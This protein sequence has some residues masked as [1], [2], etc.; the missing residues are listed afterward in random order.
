[1][2]RK[3]HDVARQ[4]NGRE[5]RQ[6]SSHRDG[7]AR[8]TSDQGWDESRELFE[9]TKRVLTSELVPITLADVRRKII[10]P[11]IHRVAEAH[12]KPSMRI[13]PVPTMPA[14]L[15][16]PAAPLLPPPLLADESKTSETQSVGLSPVKPV[17]AE[18]MESTLP[19]ARFLPQSSTSAKEVWQS[20]P[21]FK[22]RAEPLSTTIALKA[23]DSPGV[24]PQLKSK[25][26]SMQV[27]LKDKFKKPRVHSEIEQDKVDPR[28][29]LSELAPPEPRGT[30][31]V[32]SGS[33]PISLPGRSRVTKRPFVD[34]RTP[35]PLPAFSVTELDEEDLYFIKEVIDH[36]KRARFSLLGPERGALHASGC[37]R[38]EGYYKIPVAEKAKYMAHLYH[39][40]V[41]HGS[42][43]GASS[44]KLAS[45]Q[46][47][48]TSRQVRANHRRLVA[49]YEQTS[50]S[51]LLKFNQLKARKKRLR[52]ARSK[53]HEWGLF[54]L[55]KIEP[56]DMVIEYIGEVVAQHV[57]DVR[58]KRYE[59]IGI[60]SSYLFRID[61]DTIIDATKVGNLAR[62]INH[63][64]DVSGAVA[65]SST[66][67][68]T[69]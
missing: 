38:A 27:G 63:C 7:P 35:T 34:S 60:G 26:E 31:E 56:N 55:E 3:K 17:A 42:P 40:T 51:D 45:S 66:D 11:M 20:L 2:T 57:A 46:S 44:S 9:A 64:C 5:I 37:A 23:S 19:V 58:E 49:S 4:S 65:G 18:Y 43:A 36:A 29:K 1:M 54:A 32:A 8:Y 67:A 24:V 28:G 52:F 69:L 12:L 16:V 47:R 6:T 15:Q 68:N 53:I 50:S 62:F 39:E 25:T 41:R 22:K 14:N 21:S 30:M 48:V 61:E 33:G 13:I 59:R 10:E